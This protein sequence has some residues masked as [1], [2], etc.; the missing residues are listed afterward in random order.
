MRTLRV[1]QIDLL[2][3]MCEHGYTANPMNEVLAVEEHAE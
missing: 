3:I 1:C 2:S